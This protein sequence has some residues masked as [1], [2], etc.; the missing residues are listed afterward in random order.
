M[1]ESVATLTLAPVEDGH[2]LHNMLRG[3][4]GE[5]HKSLADASTA[6]FWKLDR[7][8]SDWGSAKVLTEET[9]WLSGADVCIKVNRDLWDKLTLPA[10]IGLLDHLLSFLSAKEEGRSTMSTTRG[11]RRLFERDVPS[12]SVHPLVMARNPQLVLELDELNKLRS[13]LATPTQF[14]LEFAGGAADSA[15]DDSGADDDED[16]ESH[17]VP[18]LAAV[19]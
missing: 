15:G 3:L 6:V 7:P 11:V 19:K 2:E 14:A 1:P 13:A 4:I 18:P 8:L 16:G 5:H 10:R 12:L 17:A 9:W